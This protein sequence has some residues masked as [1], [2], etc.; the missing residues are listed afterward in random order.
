MALAMVRKGVVGSTQEAFDRYLADGRPCHIPKVKL[1]PAEAI[2]L[3][4]SA[5]AVTILAHP[6]YV[7]IVD[8][9]QLRA[10]LAALKNQGL[11]GIEVFYSQHTEAET[12]RYQQIAQELDFAISGGSD[13][14]GR[15]KPNVKLGVVYQGTGVPDNVLADLQART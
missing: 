11:D 15:S 7:G 3:L 13:F 10:E 4:H 14:H 6:K 8:P 12:G 5:G 1:L 9:A 2:A